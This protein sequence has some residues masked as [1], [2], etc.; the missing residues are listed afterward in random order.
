ME[1]KYLDKFTQ[2]LKEVLDKPPYL[3]FVFVGAVFMIISLLSK[4]YFDQIWIFFLY[5][6]MGAVWRYIEKDL[7]GNTFTEGF[8][9][10]E[11]FKRFII[12]V[13]HIGN[14]A[15]LIALLH[16]LKLI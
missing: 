15:L 3:V 5:S 16:Y 12:L 14:I 4:N 6:A 8:K 13:Y 9:T 2:N 11:N 1:T 10:K 7:I